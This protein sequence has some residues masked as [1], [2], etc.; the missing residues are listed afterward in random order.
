M[1]YIKEEEIKQIKEQADIVDIVSSYLSLQQKGKNFVSVCPFHD[2]H[3]PSLVVSREKQIFNCFTCR[4]G[5]NVFNFVMKYENV[6]F[7]EAL[8]IVAEKIGYQLSTPFLEEKPTL[9]KKE[10]EVMDL[11]KKIF[12]NNIQT[13]MGEEAK[14]YLKDR[15]IDEDVIKEF[16]IGLSLDNKDSLSKFLLNKKYE[17]DLLD[18]LG[19]VNK[20]GI[21]VYDTFVNRIMIPICDI[22]GQVVGFTGRIFHDEDTAKYLNTKETRIFKKGNILFNY[23]NARNA[24]KASKEVIVVE[25]N[26]DAIT[27][28]ASGIKN[29]VALMGVSL[30]Q[31]QIDFLKKLRVPVILSLDN[32]NAGM[33]ATVKLGEVL[34][35]EKIDVK[36]ACLS[37]AKDPDEYIRKF[38]KDA[39]LDNVKHAVKFMDFKLDYLKK[40]KN[41]EQM[42]DLLLYVNQVLASLNGAEDLT[43]ELV[44]SKISKDYGVDVQILKKKIGGEQEKKL[45]SKPK[46][47]EKKKTKY[48][49]AVSKILYAM[50]NDEKFILIYKKRLGYFKEK[51]DRILATEIIYYNHEYGY[52]N[53]ADFT[54]FITENEEVYSRLMEIIQDNMLKDEIE[55]KDF[56]LCIEAVLN[57]YKKDDI[58]LLKKKIKEELDIDK[59]VKLIEQLTE[60]KKGSVEL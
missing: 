39:Y 36:V 47:V 4:T 9:F 43:K 52:I 16:Q 10:Y 56:L 8:K 11:A 28:S 37:G 18:E 24:I 5:G 13:A 42:E 15:G 2:D 31:V 35:E 22:K 58:K 14:R 27:V 49:K 33:L 29:V 12:M 60:L 44:L 54:S 59:K 50:M 23:H 51:I 6:S 41:L 30:S 25:G 20:T 38:G 3:S 45:E 1:G 19:L 46:I 26:M 7:P 57:E 53:I 40:D 34:V 48:E 21:S 55:E 17:L 32:D